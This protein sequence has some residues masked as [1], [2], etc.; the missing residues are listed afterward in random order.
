MYRITFALDGLS[1]DLAV[2]D[3]AILIAALME[4][5]VL[6]LRD[7]PE[8]L[9]LADLLRSGAIVFEE[10]PQG[11]RPPGHEDWTDIPST[12]AMRHDGTRGADDRALAAWRA[13]E[14]QVRYGV[15]AH[16]EFITR[17]GPDG[18]LLFHAVVKHPDGRIEDPSEG[19]GWR[20]VGSK[21]Y[22][23][24]ERI[25]FVLMLFKG[26]HDL[27]ISH[28]TLRVLLDALTVVDAHY[29]REHPETPFIYESGV[30]YEEEPP[31]Q[32]DW[33]DIPTTL[34]MKSGDCDDL[35]CWRAA[36]F[37][38]RFHQPARP[39]FQYQVRQDGS[40]LYHITTRTP[41]GRLEDPSRELGMR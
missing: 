24:R 1:R 39:V 9:P 17:N 15:M 37:V 6:Y 27:P 26:E 36:E 10:D 2:K 5:D 16:P 25:T 4:T 22:P 8:T 32:E 20:G 28:N 40:Y 38:V 29:L 30:R 18:S 35:S 21:E 23:G 41:D 33:Q 13:A 19:R 14:L 12:L 34:R 7:H 11:R 3:L 31:G